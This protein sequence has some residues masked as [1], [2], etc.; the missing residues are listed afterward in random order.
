MAFLGWLIATSGLT[1]G[2]PGRY[3][4]TEDPTVPN[5]AGAA[6][7]AVP[8]S[9]VEILDPGGD[10]TEL[11]G[12]ALAADGNRSTGWKTD[13][14]TQP[15]FGNLPGKTGMGVR[16]DLGKAE[17]IRQVTV[18]LDT[19]G[20]SLELRTGDGSQDPALYQTIGS[21]QDA[22]AEVT[23]TVPEGVS[24]RYWLVWITSLPPRNDGYG[25]EVQEVVLTR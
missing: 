7:R 25:V 3:P 4:V 14:Y 24:S 23:F 1:G 19:A 13:Q 6:G 5:S 16:L 8:V 17:G 11:G 21:R 18:R 2:M 22:G 10:G 12:A 9:A 15:R 20:A